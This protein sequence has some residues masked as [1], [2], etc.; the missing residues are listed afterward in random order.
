MILGTDGN[1]EPRNT[2]RLFVSQV[3]I[4]CIIVSLY[5]LP[6]LF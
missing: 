1:W 4:F 6:V 2:S 5:D 3:F